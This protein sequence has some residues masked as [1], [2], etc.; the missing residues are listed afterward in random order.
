MAAYLPEDIAS[1]PEVM[2]FTEAVNKSYFD[3]EKRATQVE[4]EQ[5]DSRYRKILEKSSEII[6]KSNADGLFTFVNPMAEKLT[7]YTEKELLT[8]RYTDLIRKDKVEEVVAFYK[9]QLREKKLSTYYEFPLLTKTGEERWLGQSVQLSELA[10]GAVEFTALAIDITTRLV[11]QKRIQL[12]KEKYESIITNMNLGLIEVDIEERIQ[13]ANPGFSLISGYSL[14]E[15][16]GK[17][18]SDVF[19]R[20]DKEVIKRKIEDRLQGVS[21]MYEVAVRNKLGEERWWMISGAPN[22]NEQGNITGSIGIH[23]DI[24]EHKKLERELAIQKEKAEHSAKAQA[25]F[26]ANMSHEIRTPLNGII[27]MIRELSYENLQDKQRKYVSNASVASQHLLSVLNN[28]LDISKIE[29]GELNL[30]KHHFQMKDVVRD[31]KSIMLVRAREKGLLLGVD[32]HEIKDLVYQGDA[33]RIRQIL[34]NLVGN[35]IKF[36]D[37]GGVYLD[38]KIDKTDPLNHHITFL[39]EDTGIGM[40]EGYKSQLFKKFSQEDSSV[41]RKYGGTGLGMAI[42]YELI[43]LMKGTIEVDSHKNKGTIIKITLSLP[44]GDKSKVDPL[45]LKPEHGEMN[46]KVLLVEDNEFNRAVARNTLERFG[47]EVEEAENGKLAIE[48]LEKNSYDIVLMDLQM[49][50]MDGFEA[51]R[52]IREKLKSNLPIIALTANAFKSELE[53]CIN[54]GMNDYVTKPYDEEKLLAAIYQLL[55]KDVPVA[56]PVI[57][58]TAKPVSDPDKLYDLSVLSKQ[59]ANPEYVKKMITIF[60][61]QTRELVP[62]IRKAYAQNDLATVYKLAH[63]VKP[64]IDGMGIISLKETVRAIELAAHKNQNSEQLEQQLD[65]LCNTLN[66]VLEQL[67]REK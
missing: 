49:P 34:L 40:E 7:G 16:L 28:V 67:A 3:F 27:G 35:S 43:H 59:I 45:E 6:Y 50:V 63:R 57:E 10:G 47:C 51:T 39:V 17:N 29:A 2:A 1:L 26:L 48:L 31:V 52:L 58:E 42:T 22:Y 4:P 55:H 23:L 30:D 61:D 38:C 44:V 24:T 25:T 21:D 37:E 5:D 65:A 33:S 15:L 46:A 19:L 20:K 18:A 54:I 14:E 64:S 8:M 66:K 13:Y 62:E 36:T 9:D 56:K 41:S 60:S 11:Y 12:L 32:L 53:Q